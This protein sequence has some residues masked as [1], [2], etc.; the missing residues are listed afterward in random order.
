MIVD[1]WFAKIVAPP[2]IETMAS[3]CTHFLRLPR[4]LR[5]PAD[6]ALRRAEHGAG[7]V[8]AARQLA[9]QRWS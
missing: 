7:C 8:L 5:C 3:H 2:R 1:T 9:G 4:F 6:E